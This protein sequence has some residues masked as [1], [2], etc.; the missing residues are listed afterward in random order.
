MLRGIVSIITRIDS[1]VETQDKPQ[2]HPIKTFLGGPK[3]IFEKIS[4]ESRYRYFLKVSDRSGSVL[5]ISKHVFHDIIA[6]R[7]PYKKFLEN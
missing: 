1:L 7:R 4:L 3:M 6:S 5:G 2:K